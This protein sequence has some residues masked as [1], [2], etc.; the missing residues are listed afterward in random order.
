MLPAPELADRSMPFTP[1][2]ALA[3]VPL[4][5][6][7]FFAPSA[8]VIGSMIPDLPMFLGGT[9]SYDTTHSWIWGPLCCLP[10]G[11]LSFV[12]F[13]L[14]RGPALGFAPRTVRC[15]LAAYAPSRL[16]MSAMA[17]CAVG[18]SIAVGV[19]T[20][21]LWDSFTHEGRWGS[22][23][24]PVLARP[25]LTVGA[26]PFPGYKVLQHGSSAIGLP[27][28]GVVVARRY[29]R[30]PGSDRSVAAASHTRRV[31]AA[32][33]LIGAPL[34]AIAL[35]WDGVPGAGLDFAEVLAYRAV[36]R[37]IAVYLVGF[38]ALT[39]PQGLFAKVG[40]DLSP[41]RRRG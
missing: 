21:I 1:T 16:R 14:G 13:R 19:W 11:V 18:L 34:A 20:H 8:L 17:W 2:H 29:A 4:A 15:R 31:V 38:V 33:V 36:T 24:L 39:L 37:T 41:R 40:M 30:A 25:W 27:L 9:P 35:V 28:L 10:Y 26:H 7:R 12:L 5:R 32:A 6:L 22:E 23:L 3:V